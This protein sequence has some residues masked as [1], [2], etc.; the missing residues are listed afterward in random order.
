MT[1]IKL[2]NSTLATASGSTVTLTH[3]IVTGTTSYGFAQ[4]ALTSHKTSQGNITWDTI[5]GDTTNITKPNSDHLIRLGISGIYLIAAN[6]VARDTDSEGERVVFLNLRQGASAYLAQT[7][8]SIKKTENVNET[9]CGASLTY[10]GPIAANTDIFFSVTSYQDS[11]AVITQE[12]HATIVLLRR[13][14]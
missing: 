3:D 12:T 10:T 11:T 8:D 7:G 4:L 2:N 13:T 9:Y 6:L 1:D 14:A 5:T